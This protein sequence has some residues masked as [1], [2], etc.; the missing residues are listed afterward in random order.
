MFFTPLTPSQDARFTHLH[1]T[2]S[3]IIALL[4]DDPPEHGW[5]VMPG[6][7]ENVIFSP[8]LEPPR[9]DADETLPSQVHP[10]YPYGRPT[11]LG[12]KNAQPIRAAAGN[13]LAAAH[14][15]ALAWDELDLEGVLETPDGGEVPPVMAVSGVGRWRCWFADAYAGIKAPP[16]TIVPGPQATPHPPPPLAAPAALPRAPAARDPARAS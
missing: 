13:H 2:E 6:F 7:D 15:D 9:L 14:R 11:T 10:S 5:S 16:I 3:H 12:Q 1:A 4:T 8:Y